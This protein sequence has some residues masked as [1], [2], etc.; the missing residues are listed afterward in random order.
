[1]SFSGNPPSSSLT[2]FTPWI[3]PP[4]Y[5]FSS[6]LYSYLESMIGQP[7][8]RFTGWGGMNEAANAG[9][10]FVDRISGL[11]NRY[12]NM[13]MPSSY[14]SALGSLSRFLA[15]SFVNPTARL[16]MGSPNYFGPQAVPPSNPGLGGGMNAPAGMYGGPPGYMAPPP[17][18]APQPMRPWQPYGGQ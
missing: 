12:G 10:P 13:G 11:A 15:P 16:Q 18:Q 4:S 2:G 1:M 6:Q 17:P 9:N 5:D 7:S 14:G 8:P 3:K